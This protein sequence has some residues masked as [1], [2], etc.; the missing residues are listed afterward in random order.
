MERSL[1]T[2]LGRI[3]DELGH[4]TRLV[5]LD[6]RSAWDRANLDRIGD[7]LVSARGEARQEVHV[8]AMAARD[9]WARLDHEVQRL[10]M[11]VG[12]AAD[13]AAAR[14]ALALSALLGETSPNE[15]GANR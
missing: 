1:S 7:E 2:R 3:R 14:I 8:G 15:T 5:A 13:D 11:N 12:T 4:R 6:A 9:A 10:T